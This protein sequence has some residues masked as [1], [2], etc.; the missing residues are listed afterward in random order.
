M[1]ELKICDLL[2]FYIKPYKAQTTEIVIVVNK[3]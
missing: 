1:K 3:H 2:T